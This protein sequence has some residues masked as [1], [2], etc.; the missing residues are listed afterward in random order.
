MGEKKK[1]PDPKTTG[2]QIEKPIALS[3]PRFVLCVAQPV[4]TVYLIGLGGFMI[5][6]P[7]Q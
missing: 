7:D 5:S 4:F 6:M 2:C 3:D 1:T